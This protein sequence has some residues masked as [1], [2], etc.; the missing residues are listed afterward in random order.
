MLFSYSLGTSVKSEDIS[1]EQREAYNKKYKK[2][3]IEFGLKGKELIEREMEKYGT[4][5]PERVKSIYDLS[6][7][8][9]LNP[10]TLVAA[11]QWFSNNSSPDKFTY[12]L[13]DNSNFPFTQITSLS[14]EGKRKWDIDTK[15]NLLTYAIFLRDRLYGSKESFV[16]F[17]TES[18]GEPYDD[19]DYSDEFDY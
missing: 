17:D 11:D 3:G 2:E 5:S 7:T 1:R 6:N 8:F 12:D 14:Y 19:F 18:S 4:P 10:K 13:F 16:V 15:V 9:L